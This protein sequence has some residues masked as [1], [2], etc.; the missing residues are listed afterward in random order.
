VEALLAI[1]QLLHDGAREEI[2]RTPLGSDPRAL[3]R[4]LLETM[5]RLNRERMIAIM[6]DEAGFV[7]SEEVIADGGEGHIQVSPRALFGRAL[8]LDA[9]RML[10]AHNHPSG[11][12]EPSATDIDQTKELI[13]QA[14]RLGI[15]L[16][17]HLVVGRRLVVS[18]RSRGLI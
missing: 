13:L 3:Q 16:V 10:I 17:D 6:A 18:M 1:R 15:S 11:N 5:G 2:V 14:E 9:R 12:A 8:S 4:Y 7:I